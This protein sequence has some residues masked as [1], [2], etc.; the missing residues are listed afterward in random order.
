[1]VASILTRRPE[2]VLYGVGAA[3]VLFAVLNP[4]AFGRL[5]VGGAGDV[6]GGAAVGVAEGAGYMAK[7]Y[8]V[9]GL[10]VKAGDSFATTDAATWLRSSVGLPDLNSADTMRACDAALA[11]GDDLAAAKYCG[12]LKWAGGWL[13]GK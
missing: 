6:I 3:L 13:D 2:F 9:G 1:M 12:P 4:R 10:A 8:G 11:S 5:L 7:E